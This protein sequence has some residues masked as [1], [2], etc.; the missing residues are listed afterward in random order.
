MRGVQSQLYSSILP[1]KQSQLPPSIFPE[2]FPIYRSCSPWFRAKSVPEYLPAS[3]PGECT[4]FASSATQRMS[5]SGSSR[6]GR[7]SGGNSH[8]SLCRFTVCLGLNWLCGHAMR[9]TPAFVEVTELPYSGP[10][11]GLRYRFRGRF[12]PD[13]WRRPRNDAPNLICRDATNW[14]TG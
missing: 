14:F 6:R 13:N 2:I 12:A 3:R 9:W 10:G 8:D 7:A 5:L 4:G 11:A 1:L